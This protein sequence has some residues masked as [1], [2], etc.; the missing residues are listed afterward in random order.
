MSST[1]RPSGRA[2]RLWSIKEA[3]EFFLVSDKTV[4]RW[5]ARKFRARGAG[6]ESSPPLRGPVSIAAVHGVGVRSNGLQFTR[7]QVCL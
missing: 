2:A 7:R 6:R 1:A 5:I 3:A 4:R